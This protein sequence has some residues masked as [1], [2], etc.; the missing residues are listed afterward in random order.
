[1]D[2]RQ[3]I[4]TTAS[5]T[6]LAGSSSP[7]L[8]STANAGTTKK[9]EMDLTVKLSKNR[10]LYTGD[11]GYLFDGRLYN[12]GGGPYTA[13]VFHD[14]VDL[15][16]Y[17]G[18]DTVLVNPNAQLAFYPSRKWP[19]IKFRG[20]LLELEKAGVDWVAE[21]A[22]ACRRRNITPWLS[23]R[24][25]DMHASG[26]R[27]E[28]RG[29][30][31]L[32]K[33]LRYCLSGTVLNPKDG[34]SKYW[35][36]LNYEKREV[37]DHMFALISELVKDYDYEGIELD[38]LRNPYICEQIAPQETIDMITGWITEIRALTEAK[39]KE[40]GKH[41]PLGLRIPGTFGLL[42]SIGLDVVTLAQKGLI[43]F[44]SPSN[45]WATSWDMPH[46]RFRKLLGDKVT[47]YGVVE[48]APNWLPAHL[49]KDKT[50]GPRMLSAS[51]P[52]MRGNAAGKLVLGA[53]GIEFFN[54][55]CSISWFITIVFSTRNSRITT[56]HPQPKKERIWPSASLALNWR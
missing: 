52:L 24:M 56:M 13:K 29:A 16:A 27:E 48:D 31:D 36:G 18:V 34:T 44:V 33:D 6:L 50:S 49:P 55:F 10:I 3:F 23:I 46:D 43:D 2:R 47:I 1:M 30:S 5:S 21:M 51:A 53:D 17:G 26:N 8:K 4:K 14:H 32:F 45:F 28:H 22:K 7:L 39:A 35:Q 9:S 15:L 54:F 41:Y 38:W 20:A 37:R 42:K 40:I 19:R 12:P 11:C 25:N